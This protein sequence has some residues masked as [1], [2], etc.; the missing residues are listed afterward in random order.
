MIKN[1]RDLPKIDKFIQHPALKPFGK[2]LSKDI[3][4]KVIAAYRERLYGENEIFLDEEDLLKEVVE[5]LELLSK[6]SLLP[7]INAT[8]IVVHT[9]LGRS[10]ISQKLWEEVGEVVCGYS[11]LE[12]NLKNGKRGDRYG[13]LSQI[14][15]LLFA[16]FKEYDILMLN[17]NASAVFLVLNTFAKDRECI[18]SRG[19][20]VE[21]GGGF[22]I[23]DVMAS[24]GAILKEVGTTNKTRLSDY[25]NALS[26]QSEMVMKIHRSNFDIVGFFE[27]VLIDDIARLGSLKNIHSYFDLGSGLLYDLEFRGFEPTLKE[28]LESNVDII[29]FSGDKLLG[30]AQ[31]GFI[32]AKKPL[33]D[34]LKK[35]QLLRMLRADKIAIALSESLFRCYLF[36][37][38][39]SIPTIAML[40]ISQKSLRERALWIQKEL[41]IKTQ[42]VET[43][44]YVG[45]GSMPNKK[46]P[47]IALKIVSDQKADQIQ[48]L[49]IEKYIIA[50]IEEDSVLIDMRTIF[51]KDFD[52][53]IKILNE[54]IKSKR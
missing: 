19:E 22:R 3:S 42:I 16:N 50:R 24:S 49:L 32:V 10:P 18:V 6:K 8:G 27:E 47:S 9:N 45:G 11:N 43:V 5:H 35:N 20:L 12:Y 54:C 40:N 29:S 33:I 4:K 17:N 36:E 48:Y 37:R 51:E 15:K 39:D 21:I 25:E 28:V 7:L 26:P 14:F 44:A 2:R 53:I 1:L 34:R 46:I 38:E 31:G 41:L 30:G 23:P 52:Y 13:H